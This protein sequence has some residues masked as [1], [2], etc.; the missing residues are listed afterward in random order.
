MGDLKTT[1]VEVRGNIETY[2]HEWFTRPE[3]LANESNTNVDVPNLCGRQIM[4]ENN[5]FQTPEEYYRVSISV[6]FLDHLITQSCQWNVL[7]NGRKRQEVFFVT[8]SWICH[9]HLVLKQNWTFGK[10]FGTTKRKVV[11]LTDCTKH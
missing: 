1:L 2:H 4:R 9:T 8:I 5:R 11:C 7:K 6:P 3:Q 10:C